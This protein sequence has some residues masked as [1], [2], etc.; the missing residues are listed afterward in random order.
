MTVTLNDLVR[1]TSDM[2]YSYVQLK[3]KFIYLASDIDSSVTTFTLSSQSDARQVQPGQVLQLGT[4]DSVVTELVRVRTVDAANLQCVVKR[5][6]LGSTAAAWVASTC[7][8]QVEP[9][10]L[11]SSIIREINNTIQS[12]PPDIWSYDT[13]TTTVN[14]QYIDGYPLP[15]GAVGVVSVQYLP[16]GFTDAWD[17]VRRW[18]YDPATNNLTVLQLMEPGQALKVQYRQYPAL[19][20]SDA[21][22]LVGT[23]H[24]T[25]TCR[26]LIV[27]GALH[28]LLLGRASG[29]LVDDRAETLSNSSQR[30][31]DPVMAAVRQIY[32]LYS[33]RLT[34]ERERQRLLFPI[35]PHTT[36]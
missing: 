32:A 4:D 22:S 36:F 27:L 5:A 34:A 9:E 20:V 28:K 23:A 6:V 30:T 25:D 14:T 24:L 33:Q 8:I 19:L 7:E 16:A 2:L 11:R 17:R 35:R 12:F 13:L 3:D 21:N 1:D 18:D 29:R 31:A 15:V 26:D 10:Y